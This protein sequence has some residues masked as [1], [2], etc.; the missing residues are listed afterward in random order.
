MCG[1]RRFSTEREARAE[2]VGAIIKRNRGNQKR[3]ECRVYLC[4]RC[5]GWHLTSKPKWEPK[6]A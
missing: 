3:A 2:L 1:K 6:G 5:D 4:D